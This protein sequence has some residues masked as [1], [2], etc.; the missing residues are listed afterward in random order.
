MSHSRKH[1]H[2]LSL[3]FYISTCRPV[4]KPS[5]AAPSLHLLVP[6]PLGLSEGCP[7]TNEGLSRPAGAK[8]RMVS[9]CFLPNMSQALPETAAVSLDFASGISLCRRPHLRRNC[10]MHARDM[11]SGWKIQ[12]LAA[13]S[14]QLKRD[15]TQVL[16][17]YTAIWDLKIF[18]SWNSLLSWSMC[19]L[20]LL[21]VGQHRVIE[22][23]LEILVWV[24]VLQWLCSGTWHWIMGLLLWSN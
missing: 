5:H 13:N 10:C 24:S 16:L 21:V 14:M 20:P 11:T 1:G 17:R 18:I 6:S 8:V 7:G 19:V 15:A 3:T 23:Q 2:H 9:S 12:S 22:L 4:P